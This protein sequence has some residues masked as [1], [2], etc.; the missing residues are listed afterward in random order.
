MNR[1]VA[2]CPTIGRLENRRARRDELLEQIRALP[3]E[4]R[5]YI[6]ASLVREAYEQS[7]RTGSPD[8]IREI[9]HRALDALNG[10]NPSSLRED[11][12]AR[13]R[14]ALD[15]IRTPLAEALS[16]LRPRSP[17]IGYADSDADQA[18]TSARADEAL[19]TGASRAG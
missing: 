18:R 5:D 9:K 3:I 14:A 12:V 15:A 10:R 17:F 8:E 6:E 19:P 7:R 16:T 1:I 13:A 4:D 11:S 2:P